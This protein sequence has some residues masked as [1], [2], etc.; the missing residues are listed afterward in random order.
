MIIG[1][2]PALRRLAAVCVQHSEVE[3]WEVQQ[4]HR[5]Q[6][7][8]VL[9]DYLSDWI[10][11]LQVKYEDYNT[12]VWCEAPIVGISKNVQTGLNI[13]TTVGAVLAVSQVSFLVPPAS[14]KKAVLGNGRATKAQVS[15]WLREV[16]PDLFRLCNGDQDAID[17][18]CIALYGEQV[19]SKAVDFRRSSSV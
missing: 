4:S 3:T 14:W 7:V 6:E 8:K 10:D 13:A 17:A 18:T 16:K 2:D 9:A 5:G 1:V 11:F 19:Y 15:D 12:T